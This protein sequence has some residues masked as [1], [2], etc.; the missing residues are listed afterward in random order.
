[1]TETVAATPVETRDTKLE[2]IMGREA[3]DKLADG[4]HDHD[5]ANGNLGIELVLDHG[6]QSDHLHRTLAQGLKR[7]LGGHIAVIVVSGL[8][9]IADLLSEFFVHDST[10]LS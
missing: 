4:L 8:G 2:I 6:G 1:M 9:K 7:R 5:L 10:F 3:L